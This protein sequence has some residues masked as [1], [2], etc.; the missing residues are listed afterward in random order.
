[1][2]ICYING[3]FQNKSSASI[4]IQDRGFNFSDGVYEVMS[5]QKNKII[6]FDKHIKR[7]DRSL[8]SLRITNPM[9]NIKSLELIIKKL[10]KLNHLNDGFLY[11]QITR[12]SSSRNHLFPALIRP[13]IVIFTFSIKLDVK[14]IKKGVN[15]MLTDDLR[16]KRC[17]IKSISLLP[18]VLEKQNAH[19]NGMYESW[20]RRNNL[21]T[22]GSTSNAFIVNSKDDSTLQQIII[23]GRSYQGY[24]N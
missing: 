10:I 19:E 2:S 24:C 15:V 14:M 8:N 23:F 17:D 16:W 3:S 9:R 12:G 6:N 18:N 11:L 22:E 5:F 7:L 20:Q 13:N 1:M 4:S 21:I